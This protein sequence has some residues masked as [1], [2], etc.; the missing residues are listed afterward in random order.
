MGRFFGEDW[1]LL[2]KGGRNMILFEISYKMIVAAI[3]YPLVI[4]LINLAIKMVG[5][6]YLTNEYIIKVFA[7]PFVIIALVCSCLIVAIYSL[8]EMIFIGACYEFKKKRRKLSL[9]Q[10]AYTS[11]KIFSKVFRFKNWI[12][13]PFTLISVFA[14][15]IA[16]IMNLLIS[17]TTNNLWAYYAMKCSYKTW[18][19]FVF[20]G[21]LIYIPV[22]LGFFTV[23]AFMLEDENF[24]VCYKKSFHIVKK[25]IFRIFGTIVIYNIAIVFV[26]ILLYAIL[27]VILIVGVKILDMAYIGSAVYLS[28]LRIFRNGVKIFLV[29]VS[30]PA[31]YTMICRLYYKIGNNKKHNFLPKEFVEK[32][33]KRNRIVLFILVVV[34]ITLNVSYV[35]MAFNK[36][37]FDKVAILSDIK[38]TAHRGSSLKAPE[39]TIAAFQKAIDDMA[40]Y[41]E[42]DVQQTSDGAIIVMHDPNVY[43][44][45]GVNS[46]VWQMTLEQVKRL[47]AGTFFSQQYAGE[48]VP[49]LDEVIKLVKGKTKLNIEIKP[50]GH[51]TDLT[52]DV[53]NIINVNNFNKDCVITSFDYSTLRKVKEI[54]KDIEVGYILSVAYGNF[55]NMDDIDFFSVNASFLSKITVDAIHNAGKQVH[56]WTVD[57]TV[58][59]K[60]L[61]NKGVDN[62]ITDV[63]ITAK[64]VI[65][66]RN[67]SETL[68]N[69]IKYVFNN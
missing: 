62:I 48:K 52:E 31:S 12:L 20:A 25:H 46:Y 2:K 59:I 18:V 56:A 64:E 10:T 30:V 14:I 47:D 29:F 44:T 42:L 27:S 37:P 45:T 26:I 4:L 63:P 40:D 68:I 67:T 66:S 5:V 36:N 51:D 8:Y 53:V 21:L 55:Y 13:V 41:I 49:T 6:R 43:R 61:A 69:M 39:N 15:N 50:S 17:G 19:A 32:K 35:V 22:V 11:W 24:I 9:F 1:K 16:V 58:S 7:N 38:I 65:Y 28:A 60:N 57:N 3:I 23:H 54:D 34:A 33:P